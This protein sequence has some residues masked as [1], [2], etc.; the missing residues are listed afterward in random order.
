MKE[1]F[2]FCED[3]TI[4]FEFENED[5]MRIG[6]LNDLITLLAP[7]INTFICSGGYKE[8]DF[9]YLNTF[10]EHFPGLIYGIQTIWL[11]SFGETEL[12]LLTKW[13]NTPREDGKM[14][15]LE[16]TYNTLNEHLA[17]IDHVKEVNTIRKICK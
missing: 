14:K 11:F 2:P 9:Y 1:I 5:N 4:K 13:L 6:Q 17:M 10:N 16:I 8:D 12:N 3:C 7:K 15:I